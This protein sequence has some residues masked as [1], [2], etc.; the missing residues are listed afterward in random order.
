MKQFSVLILMGSAAF[1]AWA[2]GPSA[3]T[4]TVS[5]PQETRIAAES[6]VVREAVV[7]AGVLRANPLADGSDDIAGSLQTPSG[8]LSFQTRSLS[9]NGI[10]AK[11]SAPQHVQIRLE[12]NGAVIDH[13]I[14]YAAGTVTVRTAERVVIDENDRSVLRSFQNE[15]GR[16][17][18]QQGGFERLPKSQD[19]LWRL[20]EMYS[21]VPLGKTFAAEWVIRR[22]DAQPIAQPIR[23]APGP[24]ALLPGMQPQTGQPQVVALAC[25]EQSGGSFINLHSIADVCKKSPVR[26]RSSAH[27]Y[28]PAHGYTSKTVAYGCGASSCAGRCGAGCGVADGLGAWYQD[29]LD[30]DVCNRDHGSQL[31][32]CGD[33]WTEAA[34]DYAFGAI[35]CYTTCH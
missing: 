4:A 12:V 17:L 22:S 19:F 16:S 27:D 15:L 34:D 23:N 13:D 8:V 35:S 2:V 20:A 1:S 31:G 7:E 5:M 18:S 3:A 26:Y 21:E 14:D 29:C 32:A 11:G 30:H 10:A 6:P 9:A 25:N 33:E 28:C 24:D